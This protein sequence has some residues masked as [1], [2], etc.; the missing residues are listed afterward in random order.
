MGFLA[1]G[2]LNLY[3]LTQDERYLERTRWRSTG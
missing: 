3:L 1:G 2:Y